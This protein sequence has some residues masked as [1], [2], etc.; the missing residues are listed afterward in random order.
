MKIGIVGGGISG[1]YLAY[2]LSRDPNNKI[3]LYEE[4]DYFGGRIYTIKLSDHLDSLGECAYIKEDLSQSER[5]LLKGIEYEC[6]AGRFTKSQLELMEL[7]KELDIGQND[8]IK[9]RSDFEFRKDS[10]LVED[11][12]KYLEL[13]KYIVDKSE[14]VKYLH[15]IS[16]YN[17]I[18]RILSDSDIQY[19]KDTFAY[20]SEFLKMNARDCIDRLKFEF[21]EDPQFYILKGGLSRI[22]DELIRRCK[23]ASNCKLISSSS[24]ASIDERKE[25]GF[26]FNFNKKS[27]YDKVIV[28]VN[29]NDLEMFNMFDSL[30]EYISG[31]NIHSLM[32]IY[33]VF[34]KNKDGNIW[35]KGKKR[36]RTD[37]I[38][39]F[40]IPISEDLGL[41]M[42]YV[43]DDYSDLWLENM[44]NGTIKDDILRELRKL[45]SDDFGEILYVNGH[46]WHTGTHYNTSNMDRRRFIEG[47]SKPYLGKEIYL[48]NEAYGKQTAWI[49]S[50]IES[51]NNVLKKII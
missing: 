14:G 49:N 36:C 15:K 1:L 3:T 25:G 29:P 6:G 43:E 12:H 18:T 24:V 44:D 30:H 40:L 35:F 41:M 46:Y 48:S 2:K 17:F 33:V 11:N 13:I 47:I 51:G 9:I 39:Q 20:T 37:N 19:L 34:G 28:T 21:I 7:F 38:L 23:K 4:N 32:R 42:I 45:Y 10:G 5:N 8:F 31:I 27:V 50:A 16:L 26:L 22:V